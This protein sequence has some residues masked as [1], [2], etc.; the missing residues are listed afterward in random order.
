MNEL[1]LAEMQEVNGGGGPAGV[2]P[3]GGMQLCGGASGVGGDIR[4]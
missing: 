3:S 4:S 1:T 2:N